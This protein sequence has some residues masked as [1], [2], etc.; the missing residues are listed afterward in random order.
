M[1]IAAASTVGS[2]A[3][4][5]NGT[6]TRLAD[7]ASDRARRRA[8]AR[9]QHDPTATTSDRDDDD[10]DDGGHRSRSSRSARSATTR[11]SMPGSSRTSAETSD[12]R[13]ISRR[14]DSF[15]VPTKT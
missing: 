12:P 11:M 1:R 6:S 13:R 9:C 14:R 5:V 4:P 7:L 2:S 3:P 10:R 8:G 15:G